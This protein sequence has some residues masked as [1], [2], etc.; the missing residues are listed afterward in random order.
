[1]PECSDITLENS[2]KVALSGV[3][4]LPEG[5]QTG[6]VVYDSATGIISCVGES[7]D[8]SDSNVVCT[9]GVISAGIIDTHN[10]MQYNALAPWQHD[11]LFT[12]RYQWQSYGGYFDYRKAFYDGIKN[13]Y[14]MRYW[15]LG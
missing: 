5:V 3:L 14:K 7:C 12:S 10:H 13:A 9:E 6:H 1:M 11:E 4:L 2:T 15:S 8:V